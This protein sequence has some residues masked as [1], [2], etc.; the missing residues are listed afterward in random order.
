VP[1]AIANLI[2]SRP[3]DFGARDGGTLT[4]DYLHIRD[5]TSAYLAVAEHMDIAAG[6]AFNFGGGYPISVRDL[7]KLISRLYDG[8]EREPAFHGP[9]KATA[10]FTFGHY[11]SPSNVGMT[12]FYFAQRWIE[13]NH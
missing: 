8:K 4:F 7:V 11:Q 3:F 12:N 6:E 13:R 9:K 1:T 5:V 10:T 2:T